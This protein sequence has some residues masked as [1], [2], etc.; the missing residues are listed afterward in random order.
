[1]ATKKKKGGALAA[2]ASRKLARIAAPQKITAEELAHAMFHAEERGEA[3]RVPT[4]DGGW[5]WRVATPNGPQMI[6]PTPEVLEAL[7]QFEAGHHE[8]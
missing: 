8:H 5:A 7:A 3:E 6:K 4:E 1:M 2:A